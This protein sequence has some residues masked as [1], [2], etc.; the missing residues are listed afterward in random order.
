MG[1]ATYFSPEQAQGLDL[2]GRADVYSLGVVLYEM[3]TG[4]APFIADDPVS[5]RV[6]ARARGAGTAVARATRAFPPRSTR[7]VLT[8]MAKDPDRRYQS[9]DDLRAD[10]L[11]FERG[12]PLVGGPNRSRGGRPRRRR[13]Y[14]AGRDGPRRA[15]SRRNRPGAGAT[16]ARSS[17][18]VSRSCSCSR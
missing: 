2:D 16:G 3:L 14:A 4:V 6:Q 12:R 13:A 10:L 5:R 15:R 1:T 11:R 18:S 7:V 17:P 8:A 9:A